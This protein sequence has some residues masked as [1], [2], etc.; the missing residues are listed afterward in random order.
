MN[1]DMSISKRSL[2][3]AEQADIEEW[4]SMTPAERLDL[5]QHLREIY[6]GFKNESRKRLQRVY[7]IVKQK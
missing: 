4:R 6:Y 5:V 3:E 1:A 7:R 2:R